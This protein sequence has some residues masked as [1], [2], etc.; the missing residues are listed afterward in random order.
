MDLERQE[1]RE[2]RGII[3]D[4]I[5][6]AA[7]VVI[8]RRLLKRYI[9]PLF[10]GPTIPPIIIKPGGNQ[11]EIEYDRE[12]LNPKDSSKVYRIEKFDWVHEIEIKYRDLL[13]YN[14]PLERGFTPERGVRV[15]IHLHKMDISTG[16]SLNWDWIDE[17]NPQIIIQGHKT[18]FQVE[19][20]TSNHYL[21]KEEP[22]ADPHRKFKRRYVGDPDTNYRLGKVVM[23]LYPNTE[24]DKVFEKPASGL[25]NRGHQYTLF[26]YEQPDKFRY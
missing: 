23:R 20:K 10:V 25:R 4:V 9:I 13:N 19:I 17:D 8:I 6:G 22:N 11:V 26:F 14:A 1:Q 7:A 12:M 3:T 5:L 15:E 18:D 16:G 2:G 24:P 21:S